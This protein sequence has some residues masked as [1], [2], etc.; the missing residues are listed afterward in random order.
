MG[1]LGTSVPVAQELIN[2]LPVFLDS[3]NEGI[4]ILVAPGVVNPL[5]RFQSTAVQ[6]VGHD[7]IFVLVMTIP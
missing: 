2:R 3:S 6:C 1:F 4:T 7:V 5:R